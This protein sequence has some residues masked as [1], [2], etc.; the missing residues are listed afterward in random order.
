MEMGGRV[1][2]VVVGAAVPGLPPGLPV[3]LGVELPHAAAATDK[4]AVK[5]RAEILV[6]RITPG[7]LSS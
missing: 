2:V 7:V 1:V 6:Q 3:E 5:T 4:V